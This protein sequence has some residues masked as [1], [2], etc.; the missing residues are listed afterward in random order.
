MSQ[1]ATELVADAASEC[2]RLYQEL[3]RASN[4]STAAQEDM[5]LAHEIRISK[6]AE[7]KLAEVELCGARI[8]LHEAELH[9][10]A[11]VRS[12]PA[13][14]SHPK[15]DDIAEAVIGGNAAPAAETALAVARM[16]NVWQSQNALCTANLEAANCALGEAETA[17]DAAR[18]RHEIADAAALEAQLAAA[19]ST[20]QYHL[21]IFP[22]FDESRRAYEAAMMELWRLAEEAAK[23]EDAAE[24]PAG[25]STGVEPVGPESPA[26]D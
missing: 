11:V 10:Q 12:F 21:L 14:P 24:V 6:L 16:S 19:A 4:A 5:R 20:V 26:A 2:V 17:L 23:G 9:C 1:S 25:V 18:E 13:P 15:W 7:S 22:A 8:E 3:D